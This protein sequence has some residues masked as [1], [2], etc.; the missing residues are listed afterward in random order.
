MGIGRL[1]FLLLLGILF[2][3]ITTGPLATALEPNVPTADQVDLYNVTSTPVDMDGKYYY[4]TNNLTLNFTNTGEYVYMAV[5]FRPTI[6]FM[7]GE[8]L[9]KSY[10][11]VEGSIEF[12]MSDT[13]AEVD[14]VLWFHQFT[15]M[16]STLSSDSRTPA[17][18][19]MTLTKLRKGSTN[20]LKAPVELFSLPYDDVVFSKPG[21]MKSVNYHFMDETDDG[22]FDFILV[23]SSV[24]PH[25]S[26]T[27]TVTLRINV[28]IKETWVDLDVPMVSGDLTVVT[29]RFNR[30]DIF[31][32]GLPDE[33]YFAA[34]ATLTLDGT[35]VDMKKKWSENF[36]P[37]DE[38]VT[39]Y[40]EPVTS[41][42][43]LTSSE[44]LDPSSDTNSDS[45]ENSVPLLVPIFP[46]AIILLRRRSY[47]I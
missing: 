7:N 47:R 18:I 43:V 13:F 34:T 33:T 10:W 16:R 20:Y 14:V 8:N 25:L 35:F 19:S 11:D 27:F 5:A 42:E 22:E 9:T 15:D 28:G 26:T 46:L 6:T 41:S 45:T 4:F 39:E 21:S 29:A 38:P 36:V 24:L 1:T 17:S 23:N 12:R 3:P 2:I 44:S 31:P 37:A 40:T 30:T 32:D